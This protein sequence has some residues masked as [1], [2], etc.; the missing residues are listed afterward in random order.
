MNN[1]GQ[2]RQHL[3]EQPVALIGAAPT[4]PRLD[5]EG[6]GIAFGIGTLLGILIGS[7]LTFHAPVRRRR[8]P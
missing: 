6:A 7:K 3:F 1:R 4:A 2:Y 5:Y 8:H